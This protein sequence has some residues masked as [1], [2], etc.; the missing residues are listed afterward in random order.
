MISRSGLQLDKLPSLYF[1]I[2]YQSLRS[3][4]GMMYCH[5]ARDATPSKAFL[6][7][8]FK[9]AAL[10][11]VWVCITTSSWP[12]LRNS[13]CRPEPPVTVHAHQQSS[14][15]TEAYV[16]HGWARSGSRPQ[17]VR[18][19]LPAPI[20]SEAVDYGILALRSKSL[21]CNVYFRVR[22]CCL[23]ASFGWRTVLRSEIHADFYGYRTGRPVAGPRRRSRCADLPKVTCL[24][25][26]M[27][28]CLR[29]YTVDQQA[30]ALFKSA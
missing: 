29:K 19:S 6:S 13:A 18:K 1:L 2:W 8:R 5:S 25:A 12:P 16:A 4:V 15:V 10:L 14:K 20:L 11:S 24:H 7:M 30:L 23:S 3:G 28:A 17:R 27:S 21:L 26:V 9:R 22:F